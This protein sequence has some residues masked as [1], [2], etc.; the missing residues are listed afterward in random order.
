MDVGSSGKALGRGRSRGL[1]EEEGW[2]STLA[3]PSR[4]P[5][6]RG[7]FDPPPSWV[8]L[9]LALGGHKGTHSSLCQRTSSVSAGIYPGQH[10]GSQ[11]PVL[12]RV[13]WL[14][15]SLAGASGSCLPKN[16]TSDQ[17]T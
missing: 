11:S 5:P 10:V 3:E 14:S 17:C 16:E 9:S 15:L 2:E 13:A 7:A 6:T 12:V 1:P 8:S 4:A